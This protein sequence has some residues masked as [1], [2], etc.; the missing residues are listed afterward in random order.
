MD[1]GLE[2]WILKRIGGAGRRSKGREKE[3]CPNDRRTATGGETAFI[4]CLGFQRALATT[5][6]I[7]A[8]IKDKGIGRLVRIGPLCARAQEW[9][10]G[11]DAAFP[12]AFCGVL[13]GHF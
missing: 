13:T 1:L 7:A 6:F 12:R 8:K 5:N 4:H 11:H 3:R 10:G 9:L 2:S